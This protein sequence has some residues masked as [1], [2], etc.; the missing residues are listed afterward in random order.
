MTTTEPEAL[1]A[2]GLATLPAEPRPIDEEFL[3]DVRPEQPEAGAVDPAADLPIG[4]PWLVIIDPQ[5]IF[6]EAGSD[7]AS[8]MW[9]DAVRNIKALAAEFA[10]RVVITRWVPPQADERKGSWADYMKA[11]P[12]ADRPVDDPLFELVPEVREIEAHVIDEPTFGKWREQL[13]VW[14][15][16]D[17]H[18][19]LT[20]VSTDCCVISTALPAADAGA[21]IT[22][23]SDACAGSTP[24]NHAAALQVMGLYPPQI[25]VATTEQVLG[26]PR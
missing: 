19:I 4:G 8:P 24:E 15:G 25:T 22:V 9:A 13:P 7:W 11:W 17:P 23:V 2:P 21:T 3:D 5:R 14:L 26:S 10:G 1:D 12:F 18:L 20:G 6:A 16:H